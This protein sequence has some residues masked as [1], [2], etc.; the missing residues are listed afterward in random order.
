[1]AYYPLHHLSPLVIALTVKLILIVM[2]DAHTPPTPTH[3]PSYII[4]YTTITGYFLQDDPT[5]NDSTFDYVKHPLHPFPFPLLPYSPLVAPPPPLNFF[6]NPAPNFL[7]TCVKDG[8]YLESLQLRSDQ[9]HIRI[10]RTR[11]RPLRAKCG[12]RNQKNPM[13]TLSK[14]SPLLKQSVRQ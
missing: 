8:I 5:T 7:I 12:N 4:K 6:F 11:L 9:P 2:V 1:M 14:P 3:A 10:R 13:A